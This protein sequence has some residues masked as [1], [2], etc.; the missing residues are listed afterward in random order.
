MGGR[1]FALGMCLTV[2]T[3]SAFYAGRV[4]AGVPRPK[5]NPISIREGSVKGP[6]ASG[7]SSVRYFQG[8][9][10]RGGK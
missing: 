3:G 2:L 5:K 10:F 4:G 9:G 6:L 8:G 7:R 1:V